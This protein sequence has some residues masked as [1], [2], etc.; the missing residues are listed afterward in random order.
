MGKE[1][2]V[3]SR[4]A[5]GP[6]GT[7]G[8]SRGRGRGGEVGAGTGDRDR[9][10]P[11]GFGTGLQTNRRRRLGG[12]TVG[13]MGGVGESDGPRFRPQVVGG[14]RAGG[15]QV[16]GGR[17]RETHWDVSTWTPDGVVSLLGDSD[18]HPRGEGV[19]RGES[20]RGPRNGVSG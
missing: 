5:V 18:S 4:A 11:G 9:R 15:V 1:G 13:A 17:V 14:G 10:D 12:V 3:G 6:G 7:A 8:G 2:V 19:D 20:G 16:G